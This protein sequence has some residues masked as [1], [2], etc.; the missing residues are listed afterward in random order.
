M[1]KF[2]YD[3]RPCGAGK[4]YDECLNI[5]NNAGLYLY[6]VERKAALE[7]RAKEIREMAAEA[8][9]NVKVATICSTGRNGYRDPD[10]IGL[11]SPSVRVRVQGLH[12]TYTGGHVVVVITHEA[13]KAA[14]LSGFHGWRL[15][16]DERPSIWDRQSLSCRLS[17]GLL[18]Q[19][20]RLEELEVTDGE[21]INR[22]VSASDATAKEFD[23]D[24]C[25]SPLAVLSQRIIGDRCIVATRLTSFDQLDTDRRW[26]WWSLWKPTALLVFERVTV[27]AHAL[28]ASIT[29]RVMQANWPEIEWENLN[30]KT[31][32]RHAH[33]RVE[34]HYYA[35]AHQASRTL[36]G[37]PVGRRFLLAIGQDIARRVGPERLIWTCNSEERDMFMGMD[38]DEPL[39]P[40][41]FLTPRQQGSN[42]WQASNEA[43][44]LY[45]AKPSAADISVAK[46]IGIS[47][48]AIVETRELDIMVQFA[49]RTSVRVAESTETVHLYVYDEVQARHLEAYFDSTGY[50]DVVLDLIDSP[51][52][53]VANYERDSTPGRK[54]KVLTRE[55]VEAA[56]I[57]KREKA[58][59]RK[60]RQRAAKK[61]QHPPRE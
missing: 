9:V 30:R 54:A 41:R 23:E 33:R 6:A 48:E 14:D 19:H 10:L 53:G 44:I 39:M 31:K 34:V 61:S 17:K 12:N 60:R 18:T 49:C 58:T 47:P 32:L 57:A 21:T 43:A 7:E 26:E 5:I 55:E 40:G 4:S 29:Y 36:W 42:R 13:L 1:T 37:S 27:L 2:Y 52:V 25:G 3:E 11:R 28:T 45:T 35:Q 38:D 24:T 59:A 20:F 15:V 16:I 8:G 46:L 51:G 50:C 56:Q 22:I